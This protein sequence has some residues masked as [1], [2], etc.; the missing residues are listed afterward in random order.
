MYVGLDRFSESSDD[1]SCSDAC[2]DHGDEN[3]LVDVDL[4]TYHDVP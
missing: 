1:D 3:E 4:I 2:S